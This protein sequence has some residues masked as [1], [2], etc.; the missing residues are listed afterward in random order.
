M[1]QLNYCVVGARVPT[2]FVL[3]LKKQNCY[4]ILRPGPLCEASE[5]LDYPVLFFCLISFPAVS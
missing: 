1:L 2:T 5:D 4:L 3:V